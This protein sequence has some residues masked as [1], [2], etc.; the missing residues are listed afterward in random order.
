MT[1]QNRAEKKIFTRLLKLSWKY[2]VQGGNLRKENTEAM[3][4]DRS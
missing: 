1:K 2:R 4:V 3:V